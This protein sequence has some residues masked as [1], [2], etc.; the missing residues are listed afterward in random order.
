MLALIYAVL[1]LLG[2]RLRSRTDLELEVM[3]CLEV[4]DQDRATTSG[5]KSARLRNRQPSKERDRGAATRSAAHDFEALPNNPAALRDQRLPP[6]EPGKR[7]LE[8]VA[9]SGECGGE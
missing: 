4:P 8:T 6:S 7:W 5:S 9:T 1:S 2:C 3:N